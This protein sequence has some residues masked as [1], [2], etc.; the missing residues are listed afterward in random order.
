Q[1]GRLVQSLPGTA[2]V[3][4]AGNHDTPRSTE[5]GGILQL[6]SQLGIYVV[7]RE[8]TPITIPEL[9]LYILGVPDVPGTRPRLEPTHRAKYSVLVLHG[10]IPGTLAPHLAAADPSAVQVSREELNLPRWTYVAL[11]HHHVHSEI[12]PH[13]CY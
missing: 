6:F 2:V 1:F 9:D 5:T 10:D 4:V 13:A 11:G 7:D 12:A 8:A 3:M